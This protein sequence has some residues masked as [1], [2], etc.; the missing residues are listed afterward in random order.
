L[1][2]RIINLATYFISF[3]HE[4][5]LYQLIATRH[6]ALFRGSVRKQHDLRVSTTIRDL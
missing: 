1:R 3:T 6:E 2:E 4:M 5:T